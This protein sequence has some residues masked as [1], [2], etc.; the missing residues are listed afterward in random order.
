MP[1]RYTLSKNRKN[2]ASQG[3]FGD[4]E[5]GMVDGKLEHLNKLEKYLLD[6]KTTNQSDKYL[7]KKLGASRTTNPKTGL[8]ENFSLKSIQKWYDSNVK[9]VA[10]HYE[11]QAKDIGSHWE[12]EVKDVGSHWEKE[13]K[14]AMPEG[15]DGQNLHRG[16]KSTVDA[17]GGFI[18]GMG[19]AG[20]D[21]VYNILG[22]KGSYYDQGSSSGDTSGSSVTGGQSYKGFGAVKRRKKKKKMIGGQGEGTETSIATAGKRSTR[23]TERKNKRSGLSIPSRGSGLSGTSPSYGLG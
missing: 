1:G 5:I 14:N 11:E 16:I 13:F 4:T 2:L 21:L 10:K 6:N 12:K 7:L 22:G 23:I 15:A 3:R 19:R 8:T 17:T 20:V 18:T 9:P